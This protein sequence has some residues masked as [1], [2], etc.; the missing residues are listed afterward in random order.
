MGRRTGRVALWITACLCAATSVTADSVHLKN[1]DH[2]S[3]KVTSSGPQAYRVQTA[4]GRLLI[5]KDK[6]ELIV[7][8]DGREEVPSDPSR[9]MPAAK[10]PIS[11]LDIVIRG[12]SFWRAWDPREAPVD[13]AL[14]LLISVDGAAVA[15]YTDRLLDSDIVGAVV[16]TFA[17]NPSATSRTLWNDTRA[18]APEAAPGRVTLR[19]ELTPPVFGHRRLSLKY[20]ANSGPATDP[21]WNDLVEAELEFEA[22]E[23]GPSAV[24]A[25]Q[26]R[27]TMTFGGL[28][29]KKKMH[30]AETF[31]VKLSEADDAAASPEP[32]ATPDPH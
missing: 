6:I 25:D 7:Y 15:A 17:F 27:G 29:R 3:G 21:I 24:N 13:P 5:P 9:T 32:S 16:N 28:L 1:G 8:D 31:T 11:R 22:T 12:D 23:A 26:S 20:Q 19:L 18:H 2:V 30:N 10:G 4:Y 14:R